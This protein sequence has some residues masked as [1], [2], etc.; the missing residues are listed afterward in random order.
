MTLDHDELKEVA[1]FD[2]NLNP[3]ADVYQCACGFSFIAIS[4]PTYCPGCGGEE[5]KA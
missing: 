5:F 3:R 4:A 2:Q 1:E